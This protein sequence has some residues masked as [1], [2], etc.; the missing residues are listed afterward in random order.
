IGVEPHRGDGAGIELARHPQAAALLEAL[1]GRDAPVAPD[2]VDATVIEAERAEPLLDA[3]Y[4]AGLQRL[5]EGLG[6]RGSCRRH[7]AAHQLVRPDA[8]RRHCRLVELAGHLQPVA[9]L[10]ALQRYRAAVAPDAVD[11]AVIGAELTQPVLHLL[12]RLRRQ[13]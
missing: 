4:D 5:R 7:G 9:L 12:D 8:E 1:H 6:W 2:A 13:R 11:G 10:E 3:A